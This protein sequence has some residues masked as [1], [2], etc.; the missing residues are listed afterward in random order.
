MNWSNPSNP[1]DIKLLKQ[2]TRSDYGIG[3]VKTRPDQTNFR[4]QIVRY[5]GSCPITKLGPDECEAA[6]IVPVSDGG[7]YELTNGLLL[8]AHIHKTFDK[9]LWSINPQTFQ[10][11]CKP[12]S[13]SIQYYDPNSLVKI[14]NSQWTKSLESHWKKFENLF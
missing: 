12:G 3:Q 10:I 13:G 8:G 11:V 4:S 14:I 9:F 2:L 5:F 7:A 1:A 6:H